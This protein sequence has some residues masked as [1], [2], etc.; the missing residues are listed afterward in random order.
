MSSEPLRKMIE[1]V[2]Y[3]DGEDNV[4]IGICPPFERLKESDKIVID[5]EICNVIDSVDI[6]DNEK[7]YTF[8]KDF[9][10]E[11]YNDYEFRWIDA[12]LSVSKFFYEEDDDE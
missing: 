12:R 4:H 11:A 6:F 5:D 1:L 2:R 3:V 7:S 8:L 9:I 10:I